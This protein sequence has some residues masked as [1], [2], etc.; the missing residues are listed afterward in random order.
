MG[1]DPRPSSGAIEPRGQGSDHGGA[2]QR[3]GGRVSPPSAPSKREG[4]PRYSL[5]YLGEPESVKNGYCGRT[6]SRVFSVL[7]RGDSYGVAVGID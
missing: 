6:V 4:S 3:G 2:E 1:L 7:D 5:G